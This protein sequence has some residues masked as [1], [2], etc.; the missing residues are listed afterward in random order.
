MQHTT[1]VL[2]DGF[3]VGVSEVG[4]GPMTLV[5]LHGLTVSAPAYSELFEQLAGKGMRVIGLDAAN[6]GRSSSLPWGHTM[7]DMA[8]ITVRALDALG[9]ERAIFAGH[10]MGGGL[11][12]EVAARNP[13]RVLGAVLMDAATGQE[14]HDSICVGNYLTFGIRAAQKLS[15]AVLDVVGDAADAIRVRD[16][17]ERASL[18]GTLRGS[19]SGLRCVKAAYALMRA[20]TVPLLTAMNRHGVRTA[21]L[22]GLHDQIVPYEAGVSTARLTDG[23]FYAVDGFHSW[24]LV[25]PALAADLI[26]LALLDLFPRRYIMGAS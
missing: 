15:A 6:H 26:S 9:I 5:F 12:A 4:S 24:M 21:V 2:D 19:V 17:G 23:V 13:H 18:V 14:H 20:N 1:I 16:A 3:R 7:A 11:V 8:D 10:S 22:H 25:D